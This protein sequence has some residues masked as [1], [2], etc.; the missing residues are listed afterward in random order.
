MGKRDNS[1]ILSIKPPQEA[2]EGIA[3]ETAIEALIS[4]RERVITLLA[5]L[6]AD[7]ASLGYTVD[8]QQT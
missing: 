2:S 8:E 7:L 4:Q 5:Q 1:H 3:T 6:D